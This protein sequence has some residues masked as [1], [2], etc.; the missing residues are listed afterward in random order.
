MFAII[1]IAICIT[2]HCCYK[3]KIKKELHD[4]DL[5]NKKELYEIDLKYNN[6]Q[7]ASYIFNDERIPT[8][9]TRTN[10]VLGYNRPRYNRP[11]YDRES[12]RTRLKAR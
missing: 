1:V 6:G 12:N 10:N 7:N 2:V 4:I 11:E 3:L 8:P 9:N 5:K